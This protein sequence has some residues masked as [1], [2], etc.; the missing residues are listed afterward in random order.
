MTLIQKIGSNSIITMDPRQKTFMKH[1]CVAPE[2]N[3]A[4]LTFRFTT[5]RRSHDS[6]LKKRHFK[7]IFLTRGGKEG[8]FND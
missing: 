3:F 8:L 6:S 2:L 5:P 1:L 4:A 7:G